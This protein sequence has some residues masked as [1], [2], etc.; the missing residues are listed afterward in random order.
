MTQ[1]KSPEGVWNAG[2]ATLVW[3]GPVG[4]VAGGHSEKHLEGG[5]EMPGGW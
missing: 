2:G 1:E 5:G 3:W 4:E